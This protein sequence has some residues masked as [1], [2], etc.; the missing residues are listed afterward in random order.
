MHVI[1]K[2]QP[3]ISINHQKIKPPL[4]LSNAPIKINQISK[5]DKNTPIN[6]IIFVTSICIQSSF[7]ITND[8]IS[9]PLGLDIKT[10]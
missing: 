1:L 9:H 10:P 5:I 8:A 6:I 2:I 4:Q 3:N 7:P